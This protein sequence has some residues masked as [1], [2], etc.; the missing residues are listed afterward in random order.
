[1][2]AAMVGL[3]MVDCT[4]NGFVNII[5][6]SLAGGLIGLRPAHLGIGLRSHQAGALD[7]GIGAGRRT[8]SA[9]PSVLRPAAG[10]IRLADRTWR[11]GR[12]FKKEG[13]LGE[14]EA[15]W[16]Q[17]LDLLAAAAVTDPTADVQ[18]R[19]CDCANDLAW[20]RLHH[21]ELA[22]RDPTFAL[23]RSPGAGPFL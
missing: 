3:Y 11:L 22:L 13:R 18:R 12:G 15:A 20:L 17:A 16:R 4:F 6:V 7:R 23:S 14:A 2:S 21:S 1:L 9:R 5:Y 8:E 19:W 10:K